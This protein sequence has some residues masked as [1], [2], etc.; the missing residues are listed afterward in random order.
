MSVCILLEFQFGG[1]RVVV[2]TSASKLISFSKQREQRETFLSQSLLSFNRPL[3]FSY[4]AFLF[5]R[6][7]SSPYTLSLF[8][9]ELIC[10][11]FLCSYDGGLF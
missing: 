9:K 1:G 5:C 8:L 10:P 11:L 2:S 7:R 4:F 3:I 6:Y